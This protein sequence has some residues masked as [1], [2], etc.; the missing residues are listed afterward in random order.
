MTPLELLTLRFLASDLGVTDAQLPA[1]L[2]GQLTRAGTY[3]S[4]LPAQVYPLA[5]AYLLDLSIAAL[6]R[7]PDSKRLGDV[8]SSRDVSIR[9]AQ[10]YR[11]RRAA[12]T[13][14]GVPVPGDPNLGSTSEDVRSVFSNDAYGQFRPPW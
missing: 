10:L 9:L 7:K 6:L 12:Y 2:Q 8:Q 13:A 14:A 4:I 1:L 5:M 11:E 3:P